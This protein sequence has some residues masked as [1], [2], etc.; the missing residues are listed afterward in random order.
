MQYS[1]AAKNNTMDK[2]YHT[3]IMLIMK[4]GFDFNKSSKRYSY[5][6]RAYLGRILN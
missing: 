4:T 2:I 3:R 1:Y 5:Y 6:M